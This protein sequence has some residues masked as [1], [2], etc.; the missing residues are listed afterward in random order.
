MTLRVVGGALLMMTGSR[1]DVAASAEIDRDV[2][3]ARET[4]W[5][6]YLAGDVKALGDLLPRE[7]IGLGM[8]DGPFT[9]RANTLDEARHFR[10]RAHGSF[11]WHFR[12]PRRS[13]SATSSCSTDAT[14]Q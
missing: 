9:D 7:F 2:L 11:A 4:A 8:T 3:A 10:S 13:N 6:A 1:S 14:T 5:R 12:K